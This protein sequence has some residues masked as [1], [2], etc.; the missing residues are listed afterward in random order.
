[1]KEVKEKWHKKQT[2]KQKNNKKITY[3]SR[4]IFDILDLFIYLYMSVYIFKNIYVSCAMENFKQ[5]FSCVICLL[6]LN[7]DFCH[8]SFLFFHFRK[9]VFLF[10]NTYF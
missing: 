2:K 5:L 4:E 10:N 6:D 1:M 9:F 7:L 3:V 8:L